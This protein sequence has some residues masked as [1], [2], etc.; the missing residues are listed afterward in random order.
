MQSCITVDT[1]CCAAG[2]GQ[3]VRAL[4]PAQP[5]QSRRAGVSFAPGTASPAQS[6]KRLQPQAAAVGGGVAA[7]AVE[8]SPHKRRRQSLNRNQRAVLAVLEGLQPSVEQPVSLKVLI[9][10]V[11]KR[12]G[13]LRSVVCSVLRFR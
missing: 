8:G 2:W 10:A 5:T 7:A 6:A 4:P 9:A 12:C 11:E 3:V 1:G 13:L